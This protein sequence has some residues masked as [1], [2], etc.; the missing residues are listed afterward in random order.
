MKHEHIVVAMDESDCSTLALNEAIK[1]TQE[2]K[3]KLHVIHVVDETIFNQ[4]DEYVEFDWLW[5]AHREFGKKILEKAE[6]RLRSEKFD[7]A[8][9]LIELK[10]NEGRLAEKIVTA[11]QSLRADLLVIGT[12]GR[13]GFSRLFLGSVAE[14]VIRTATMPV[15]LVR[16]QKT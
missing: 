3:A 11:A 6:D 1:L 14:K 9:H 10:P 15:L 5:N 4:V 2:L 12:H 7:F 8:T 13:K 16:E